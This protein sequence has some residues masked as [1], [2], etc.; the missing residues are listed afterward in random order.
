MACPHVSGAVALIAQYYNDTYSFI[1]SPALTKALLINGAEDMG[2]GY[3]S[4]IQGWGRI[5]VTRAIYGPTDGSILFYEEGNALSTNDAWE[6]YFAVSSSDTPLKITLVWTDEEGSIISSDYAPKLV[7]DLDLIIIAPD[8]KEYHG[9]RFS[10]SWSTPFASDFDRLNNVENVF[11]ERPVIGL[12]KVRV[13]GYNVPSGMQNFALAIS[14]VLNPD[15]SVENVDVSKSNP[16]LGENVYINATVG[17]V[18]DA[19]LPPYFQDSF[20]TLSP[21]VSENLYDIAFSPSD[22]SALIVGE[23][24]RVLKYDGSLAT[25][26]SS[27]T[28]NLNGVD[29]HP[30]GHAL[31]VGDNGT[32]LHWDGA[33]F[34]TEA[35]YSNSLRDVKFSPDGSYALIVGENGTVYKRNVSYEIIFSDDME[36]GEDG[37]THYALA[38]SDNWALS[39]TRSHSASTSWWSGDDANTGGDECLV[40]PSINLSGTASATLTFWHWYDWDEDG[41]IPADGGI[42]EISTDGG[43]TWIQLNPLEGYDSNLNAGGWGQPGYGNPLAGR[44]AYTGLSLDWVRSSYDLTPYLGAS[45]NIRF[46]A[47]FDNDNDGDESWYI[48]DVEVIVGNYTHT[49][50]ASLN[51]TVT[52]NS[53]AFKNRTEA[54]I[55]GDGVVWMWNGSA[56]IDL[57]ADAPN[58]NDIDF[59]LNEYAI[60]VGD[61]GAVLRYDGTFENLIAPLQENLNAI[62]FLPD[63][64]SALIVGD[65]GTVWKYNSINESI[66][67]LSS[68]SNN[69][70]G[71]AF[72]RNSNVGL[73]VGDLGA[74]LRDNITA[75]LR[76]VR[77][78]L[79]LGEM[80]NGTLIDEQY[81]T[82]IAPGSN[83]TLSFQLT[84]SLLNYQ[85]YIFAD[86]NNNTAEANE[87]NNIASIQITTF[88]PEL[89]V[90][91]TDISA[92]P[93]YDGQNTTI[94]ATI[95]NLGNSDV[96]NVKVSFFY[97][98]LSNLIANDTILLLNHNSSKIAQVSWNAT[99]LLGDHLIIIVVDPDDTI[100]EMN[101]T[102]NIA[103]L[104]TKDWVVVSNVT[105][106]NQSI[107]L[108]GN[109]TVQGSL[110]FS[111]VTLRLN[112]SYDGEFSIIVNSRFY[113]IQ[114]NITAFS[115]EHDFKFL[116][117]YDSNFEMRGSELSRCGYGAG[118]DGRAGLTIMANNS[119]IRNSSFHD[120]W[121]A[122]SFIDS[123]NSIIENCGFDNNKYGIYIANGSAT[124]TNTSITNSIY[125]DFNLKL[126]TF[127]TAIDSIFG[128]N[129]VYCDNSSKLTV[130]NNIRVRV[131]ESDGITPVSGVDVQIEDNGN[132]VY[133]TAGFGGSDAQTNSTGHIPWT[134]ITDR[135]YNY[136]SI[137]TENRTDIRLSYGLWQYNDTDVNASYSR[138]ITYLN[139]TTLPYT[140]LIISGNN[141]TGV[142][143][144]PLA[145]PFVVEVQ[146]IFGNALS[147]VTVNFTI[148]TLN[149]NG[150]A[151]LGVYSAITNIS[152]RAQTIL[153]LDTMVGVNTVNAS[154][155]SGL[156]RNV[157]FYANSTP[158]LPYAIVIISGNNQWGNAGE[159][160]PLPLIVRAQDRYNNSVS[161]VN[162][163]FEIVT[164][165]L[166]GTA[167]LSPNNMP[168]NP[169]VEYV[170]TNVTGR[171]EIFLTLDTMAGTNIVN[172]S[173]QI[174]NIT[175]V[176][177]YA[178][179]YPLYAVRLTCTEYAKSTYPSIPVEYNI[180]LENIGNALDTYNITNST[181]PLNWLVML[182]NS[183]VTLRPGNSLDIT[184]NIT[185]AMN[186][187]VGSYNIMLTATSQ[188]ST[189]FDS[190]TIITTIN[191][192]YDIALHSP[193]LVKTSVNAV[194]LITVMNNGNGVDSINLSIEYQS[195]YSSL[196][197]TVGLPPPEGV[198]VYLSQ[199]FMTLDPFSQRNITLTVIPAFNSPWGAKGVYRVTAVSLGNASVSAF[200]DT[201][202]IVPQTDFSVDASDIFFSKLYILQGESVTVF[203]TVHNLGAYDN[204]GSLVVKFYD[205]GVFIGQSSIPTIW[206]GR[207]ATT[208]ITLRIT[209]SGTH[210]IL[211]AV[212]PEPL[213]RGLIIESNELNNNATKLFEVL[214]WS[215]SSNSFNINFA[216]IAI[217]SIVALLSTYPCRRRKGH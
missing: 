157:T 132:P 196:N 95:R 101:E 116:V 140:I 200:L 182:S 185:P 156:I 78:G 58:L 90:Y 71:V 73:V 42:V 180:K 112:S 130:K 72:D 143:G 135:I 20:T 106:S 207:D 175:V 125:H 12:Y 21:G 56:L 183:A 165:G 158:D 208:N 75:N 17:N 88:A 9:N 41:G 173:M 178:F 206:T 212:D 2:Y 15:L 61:S 161:G 102:N 10:N 209:D 94:N 179:S 79:Y 141:Q 86:S 92:N 45:V 37:W 142:V 152:G 191:Q 194:F 28:Y 128:Y 31:I 98:N 120:N 4:Y 184:M 96:T 159:Q 108:T 60:I 23:A 155:S 43:A 103:T 189:A 62:T 46:R 109:L 51:T 136:S 67:A 193:E 154:I 198:Y 199:S 202:T 14:G 22:S 27:T 134:L 162:V 11:I 150:D 110:T 40:S 3:P 190:I 64:V 69:L 6:D 148:T 50:I 85:L 139:G 104:T 18:G 115:T 145:E 195:S 99:N 216:L 7:N 83:I 13:V 124:I 177:F 34:S 25:L 217:V 197:W 66:F 70:N 126:N 74:V 188:N 147:G 201:T 81:I 171:A 105:Y 144:T 82:G 24:G 39:N 187:I 119:I 123:Y 138:T 160:L 174:G 57:G 215:L 89:T 118:S 204:S 52:L 97:D 65:N 35:N 77:V 48:D 26:S 36:S 87:S 127:A 203:V 100:M 49:Q 32:V 44:V 166:N 122:I 91:S 168:S 133:S 76:D 181:A 210:T 53:I 30:S 107:V 29:F 93:I 172:A 111:N 63:E 186:A 129:D 170:I 47:G 68:A 117:D 167:F 121:N 211:V 33:S 131:L 38:G 176:T 164:V 153:T 192:V 137:P 169:Q 59:L 8:G 16:N 151:F 163:T 113:I 19:Q 54:I 213:P 114:S 55:V 1:P 80:G 205:N 149:L 84:V 5:N 146:D 214:K